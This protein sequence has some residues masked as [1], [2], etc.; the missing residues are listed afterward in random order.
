MKKLLV[1]EFNELCPD[2]IEKFMAEGHLPNFKRL[3]RQSAV[4]QTLTDAKGTDLNPWVQWMDVHTGKERQEHG[5]LKLNEVKNYT[6]SYTWDVLA[7]QYGVKSW[8]C[9]SM[10]ASHGEKFKGRFLPDP[11]TI[12]AKPFPSGVMDEYYNFVS[13]S[14][15]GH[16]SKKVASPKKF[17]TSL[18]Q[19][20]IRFGTLFN[21]AVQLVGEKLGFRSSWQRAMTLDRIQLDIF[22]HH[23]KREKPDFSTFFSNAVAHY[24]HHYWRDFAPEAFGLSEKDVDSSKKEAI[25][26]AYKNTDYLLGQLLNLVEDD[27]AVIMATALSQQP[28]TESERHYYRMHDIKQFRECFNLPENAVYKPVMA[29]QFHLE[30]ADEEQVLAV[31]S[32]LEKFQMD[33]SEYFHVGTNQLFHMTH[34]DN[35]LFVQVRCTKDVAKGATFFNSDNPKQ[36]FSFYELFYQMDEVKAGM[37]SPVGMY[38]MHVPGSKAQVSS[39]ELPPSQIHK[40]ILAYYAD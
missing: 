39:E 21:V 27:C 34:N 1:M 30:M 8:I 18:F 40:D 17:V 9:G 24:Q 32:E 25:L 38:W 31:K 15:Q 5:I 26:M 4:K 19:Q 10:N 11:W 33:S 2:L 36:A 23:Y 22:R 12:D 6:G 20:G 28:F 14:V 13:K 29:E 16:S 3:Q 35:V 37:H 7:E